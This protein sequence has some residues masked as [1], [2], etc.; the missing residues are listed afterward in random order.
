MKKFIESPL[1]IWIVSIIPSAFTYLTSYQTMKIN[2]E[3]IKPHL[4]FIYSMIAL[5]FS[6][7][8]LYFRKNVI[9]K[10][11]NRIKSLEEIKNTITDENIIHKVNSLEKNKESDIAKEIN[12][13]R[14]D[15]SNEF[16]YLYL[17]AKRTNRSGN[18]L[19]WDT[20]NISESDE[21]KLYTLDEKQFL[22]NYQSKFRK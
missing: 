18:I 12:K 4:P 13:L 16:T 11:T 20:S 6:V 7:S 22:K 1:G 9:E 21:Y 8:I 14:E 15:I 19:N 10:I 5:L 3:D 17:K 2:F